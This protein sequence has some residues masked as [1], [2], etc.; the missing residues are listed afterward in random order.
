M[1]F[2]ENTDF[3]DVLFVYILHKT[4]TH[5]NMFEIFLKFKVCAKLQ[6]KAHFVC[7]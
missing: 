1:C 7:T 6:Q 4:S 5:Q 2:L 3:I